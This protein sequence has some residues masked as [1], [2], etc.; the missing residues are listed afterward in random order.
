MNLGQLLSAFALLGAT[1]RVGAGVAVLRMAVAGGFP[2]G[3][4]RD[5]LCDLRQHR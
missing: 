1:G 2:A 3:G 4:D 5:T